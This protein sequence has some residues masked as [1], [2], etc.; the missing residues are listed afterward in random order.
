MI[1]RFVGLVIWCKTSFIF[2]CSKDV[3]RI[4]DGMGRGFEYCGNESGQN[5]LVTGDKV[6]ITFRSDDSVEKRGYYLVFTLD[7]HGK[8][9]HK[10]A[11]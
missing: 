3:F 6:E 5:R 2:L 4:T 8:R 11:N 9:D 10:E 1:Y 7:S